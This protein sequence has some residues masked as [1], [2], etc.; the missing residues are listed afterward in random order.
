MVGAPALGHRAPAVRRRP[1]DRLLLPRPDARARPHGPGVQAR[2]ATAPGF[3]GNILIGRGQDYAW[4]LTSAGSDLIDNFVETLCGGSKH[5]VPLQGQVPEDGDDRR[6]HDRGL[7]PRRSTTRPSTARSSA[8]PRS[9]ARRSRSRASAPATARTSCG[10]CRSGTLTTGKSTRRRRSQRD[11]RLAVHVQRRLRGRPRHRD[12]LGRQLPLRDTHV[13]PRLPTK[14]TGEY[15]WK[16]FLSTAQH[17]FQANP[18]SGALVNWNN[19]PA[20]D[21]GAADDNWS[22]G[23]VQRVRMLNDN[24]AKAQT[25]TLA[26]V[27]SAMNAAATQDLRSVAL[28]PVITKLLDGRP[29]ALARGPRACWR[30][31]T[32]GARRAPSRLDR[33]LDGKIDAGPG[34]AIWDA[35]YPRLFKAAMPVKGLQALIGTS[36]GPSSGF[37]DGGF[38]YL[39]K[40]LRTINGEKL[41]RKFNVRYCANGNRAKCAAAVWKAL[42][43]VPGDPDALT[44]NANAERIVF[45]PGLLQTT[46]RYTN[47]PSGIQQVISFGGHQAARSGYGRICSTTPKTTQVAAGVP[48]PSWR[49]PPWMIA[50]CERRSMWNMN[51]FEPPIATEVEVWLAA[52][53][54][55]P[56]PLPTR[57]ATLTISPDALLNEIVEIGSSLPAVLFWSLQVAVSVP[58]PLSV[59]TV[60]G[61]PGALSATSKMLLN[62]VVFGTSA[63]NLPG[64]R[65]L[66]APERLV[67]TSLPAAC[68]E[69]RAGEDGAL[70]VDRAR[71]RDVAD[72]RHRGAAERH[73]Q[74]DACDH[75]GR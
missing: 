67:A 57:R 11:G 48:R 72:R 19:R 66:S 8:T 42:D 23:S 41:K 69:R 63:M 50:F 52:T 9:A 46:I 51:V 14:G 54:S 6:R 40:D 10:S 44:A 34:P 13:D 43:T 21:W 4:T 18:P 17:P 31:S 58:R 24:L 1:A 53:L 49:T 70:A 25:H 26:S 12:V 2:G 30:S 73:E 65:P 16:G 64:S 62:T 75:H 15:E 3:A 60:C 27:T 55:A 33:N 56:S 38:W 36:A 5:Q 20:P 29:V 71:V 74:R 68:D 28:T 59:A 37:T 39:E 45:R 35:L 32:S 7:G 22:Y 61:A 47:R